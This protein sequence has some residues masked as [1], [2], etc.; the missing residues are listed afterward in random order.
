VRIRDFLNRQFV[1]KYYQFSS[2]CS[3]STTAE[4]ALLALP[5]LTVLFAIIETGYMFFLAILLE[6][7]TADAARQIRTGNVQQAGAPL[8]QFQTIL[9]DRLFGMIACP[10]DVIIDVRNYSQFRDA[11]PPPIAAN[12]EGATFTP[13]NAGD[14]VVVRVSFAWEFITPFLNQALANSDGGT[15]SFI[16]SAAFRNEPFAAN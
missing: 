4:F 2:N 5:F 10:Q 16:S 15:R 13:G 7:A 3:A 11:A 9:C 14:V 12:Q 6:G 1:N 8:G